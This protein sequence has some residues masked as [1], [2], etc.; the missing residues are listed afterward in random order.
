VIA[1]LGAAFFLA[2]AHVKGFYM[3]P[4][5]RSLEPFPFRLNRNGGS[6]SLF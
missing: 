4:R 3:S 1:A 2:S 5:E 6:I